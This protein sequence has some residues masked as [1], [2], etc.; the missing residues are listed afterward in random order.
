MPAEKHQS[1]LNA[2]KAEALRRAASDD[3]VALQM[4]HLRYERALDNIADAGV[5]T[6][7]A[8]VAVRQRGREYAEAVTRYSHAAMAWLAFMETIK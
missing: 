4:A 5:P 6:G 7:E 8:M 2:S 3:F 1:D